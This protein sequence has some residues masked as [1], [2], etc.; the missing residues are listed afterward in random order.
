MRRSRVLALL[1]LFAVASVLLRTGANVAAQSTVCIT[2]GDTAVM[3]RVHVAS[4]VREAD[5]A[6]LARMSLPSKPA[7]GVQLV[8]EEAMCAAGVAKHNERYANHPTGQVSSAVVLKVGTDRY[9]LWPVTAPFSTEEHQLYFVF[10]TSWTYLAS[11][12]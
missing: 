5:P 2:T 12:T 1:A 10:D 4:L 8:T 3:A 11:I 6:E 7:A 9:V